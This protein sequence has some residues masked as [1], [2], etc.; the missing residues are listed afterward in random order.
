MST[1]ARHWMIDSPAGPTSQGVCRTCNATRLFE[2]WH[3][4]DK[5]SR[6]RWRNGLKTIT[7]KRYTTRGEFVR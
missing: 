5:P 1:H 3:R 4:E 2:N 7:E 6:E